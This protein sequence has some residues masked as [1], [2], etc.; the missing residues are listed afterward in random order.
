MTWNQWRDFVNSKLYD[1]A[2]VIFIIIF[3][4]SSTFQDM[5]PRE[6]HSMEGLVF[7]F[8][9]VALYYAPKLVLRRLIREQ[10]REE[11]RLVNLE[12]DASGEK[13]FTRALTDAEK[14][15]IY[16]A[17]QRIWVRVALAL[18]V[19]LYIGLYVFTKSKANLDP[20]LAAF[21]GIVLA[22]IGVARELDKNRKLYLDL[23]TDAVMQVEGELVREIDYGKYNKK[24]IKFI[25]RGQ[26]FEDTVT[27]GL[28]QVYDQFEEDEAVRILFSPYTKLVYTI[29]STKRPGIKF[30]MV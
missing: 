19:G 7:T 27:P 8:G 17:M 11:D 26:V 18:A 28:K 14:N 23:R 3:F 5:L 4:S 1:V 20:I 9:F 29:E 16:K 10:Q 12:M 22:G 2:F 21:L 25:V 13:R 30:E 15:H 24:F 6:R